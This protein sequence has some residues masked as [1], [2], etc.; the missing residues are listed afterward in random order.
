[1]DPKTLDDLAR[2]LADALPSGI[3]ELRHDAE[4]NLR[5]ALERALSKL[6]LV[7]R[8]E[9]DV[10]ADVLARTRAKLESLER[11]LAELERNLKAG[12]DRSN[13]G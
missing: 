11:Q 6:N 3:R 10:Q 5:V 4:K 13:G 2:K 9:F 1:M 7:S 8:E 12:G